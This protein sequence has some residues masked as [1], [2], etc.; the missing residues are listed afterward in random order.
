MTIGALIQA[1]AITAWNTGRPPNVPEAKPDFGI[2]VAPPPAGAVT[3]SWVNEGVERKNS[4]APVVR[5]VRALKLEIRAAGDATTPPYLAMDPSLEWA[6]TVFGG[7]KL[8]VEG[9]HHCAE[10][11]WKYEVVQGDRR[12]GKSTALIAVTYQTLVNNSAAAT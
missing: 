3:I 10:A 9:V 12:Y 4:T 5:R 8:G 7:S 6:T 1:A 11:Q 2:E